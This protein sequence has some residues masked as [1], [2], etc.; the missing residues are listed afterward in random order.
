MIR[1]MNREMHGR[2]VGIDAE[3]FDILQGG[4]KRRFPFHTPVRTMDDVRAAMAAVSN[5]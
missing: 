4:K 5:S 3:G 2:I 1:E